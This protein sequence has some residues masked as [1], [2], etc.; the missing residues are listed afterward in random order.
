[1]HQFEMIH[2]LVKMNYVYFH[3]APCSLIFLFLKL[4]I[5]FGFHIFTLIYNT[6]GFA[7]THLVVFQ[8]NWSNNTLKYGLFQIFGKFSRIRKFFGLKPPSDQD[9]A[10][11]KKFGPIGPAV[12]V[13][14]GNIQTY[15]QTNSLTDWRFYRV[16]IVTVNTYSILLNCTAH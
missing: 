1:M 13:E 2:Y 11:K 12:P 16:I 5:A 6:S 14:L 8:Q 3:S 9:G 10:N 7:T 4:E 15:R